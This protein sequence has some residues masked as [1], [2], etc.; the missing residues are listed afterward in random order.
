MKRRRD[1]L[2][3]ADRHWVAVEFTV[4]RFDGGD[5]DEDGVQDPEDDEENEAD[6]DEKRDP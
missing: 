6:Q 5:D 2:D 4:T 3:E 1:L